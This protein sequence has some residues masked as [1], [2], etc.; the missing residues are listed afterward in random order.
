MRKTHT[1]STSAASMRLLHFCM[2]NREDIQRI[3][4]SGALPLPSD[5]KSTRRTAKRMITN[6]VPGVAHI[7]LTAPEVLRTTWGRNWQ[8]VTFIKKL[9]LFV[10]RRPNRLFLMITHRPLLYALRL[11]GFIFSRMFVPDNPSKKHPIFVAVRYII[12]ALDITHHRK[13]TP[14]LGSLYL[15]VFFGAIAEMGMHLLC[16]SKI[17]KIYIITSMILIY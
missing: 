11:L 5:I 1:N 14:Y 9:L 10:F 15:I 16:F 7:D 8:S 13:M 2:A 17:R 3:Y 4:G 12:T 6:S